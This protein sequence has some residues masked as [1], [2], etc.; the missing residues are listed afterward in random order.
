MSESLL[1]LRE[2][3]CLVQSTWTPVLQLAENIFFLSLPDWTALRD[4]G[5]SRSQERAQAGKSTGDSLASVQVTPEASVAAVCA[6]QLAE[7]YGRL[8]PFTSTQRLCDDRNL[9]TF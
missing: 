7:E 1:P 5:L 9:G 2:F 4:L 8:Q 6:C 3:S